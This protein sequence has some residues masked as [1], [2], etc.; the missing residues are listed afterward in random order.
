MLRSGCAKTAWLKRIWARAAISFSDTC[1]KKATT[2]SFFLGGVECV[3]DLGAVRVF[4]NKAYVWV[5]VRACVGGWV[6]VCVTP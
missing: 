2:S 3:F 6:C 4:L 5:C 1:A